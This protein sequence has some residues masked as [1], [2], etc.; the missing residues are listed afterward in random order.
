M[1]SFLGICPK[2][3]LC[4]KANHSQLYYTNHNFLSNNAIRQTCLNTIITSYI[5]DLNG[6]IWKTMVSL[7]QKCRRH[8]PSWQLRTSTFYRFL[9]LLFFVAFRTRS[10]MLNSRSAV[11]NKLTYL[12]PSMRMRRRQFYVLLTRLYD[13]QCDPDRMF[14]SILA[15][16]SPNLVAMATPLAPLKFWIA[17]LKSPTPKTLLFTQNLC[18]YLVQKWSYA[19]LNVWRIFTIAGIGNFFDFSEK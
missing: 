17:Y 7:K 2:S 14:C 8:E 19:Y 18:R 11:Y 3:G 13:E 9:L 16:F 4:P 10:R 5:A 15:H 1:V 12:S 6:L